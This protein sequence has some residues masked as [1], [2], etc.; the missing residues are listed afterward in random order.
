M[1]GGLSLRDFYERYPWEEK[2]LKFTTSEA[3][4][5]FC[6]FSTTDKL[7]LLEKLHVY[8]TVNFG[9]SHCREVHP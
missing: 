4:C 8:A 3:G 2:T 9:I 5:L 7:N 1:F 6:L